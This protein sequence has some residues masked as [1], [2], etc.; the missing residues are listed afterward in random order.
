VASSSVSSGE[1]GEG[2]SALFITHDVREASA[3]ARQVVV[4]DD[5]R[6]V[7]KGT[8]ESVSREPVSER[9]RELLGR[10]A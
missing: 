4:I 2:S 6:I 7:Q 10:P 3:L 9:V 5:A 1:A 8:L